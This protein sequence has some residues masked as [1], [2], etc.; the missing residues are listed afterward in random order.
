[1]SAKTKR[2][3]H[4]TMKAYSNVGFGNFDERS[5]IRSESPHSALYAG[6][7]MAQ[8]LL[9]SALC[10]PSCMAQRMAAPNPN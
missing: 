10:G 1:M 8:H 7:C 2:D 6:M 5:R 9:L 3:T 4:L